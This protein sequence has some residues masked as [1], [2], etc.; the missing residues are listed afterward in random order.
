KA[1]FDSAGD[2][3]WTDRIAIDAAPFI[4]ERRADIW[5]GPRQGVGRG[6]RGVI[7]WN[8]IGGAHGAADPKCQRK[9][10]GKDLGKAECAPND[11]QGLSPKLQSCKRATAQQGAPANHDPIAKIYRD[12]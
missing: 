7:A 9:A 4:A 6:R 12:V 8:D 1:G 3:A 10:R 2:S 11:V 5:P